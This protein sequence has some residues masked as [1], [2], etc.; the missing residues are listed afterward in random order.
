MAAAARALPAQQP[1]ARDQA[2]MK[3]IMSYRLTE[4]TFG[5]LVKVQDDIYAALK[6]NPDLAKRYRSPFGAQGSEATHGIDGI[7]AAVD[8]VPELK[9]A[10]ASAGLTTRQY[11]L[12]SA[13]V[14]QAM[15]LDAMMQMYGNAPGDLPGALKE[16]LAF[17]NAHRTEVDRMRSRGAEIDRLTRRAQGEGDE[18]SPAPRP[19]SAGTGQR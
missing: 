10:I 14:M 6:A 18:S 13:A 2:D 5:K 19:D 4:P 16:N 15:M 7:V 17:L 11:L 1:D 9:R 12:A 3:E 8:R